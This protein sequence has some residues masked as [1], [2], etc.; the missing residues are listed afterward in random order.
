MQLS[1]CDWWPS[2]FSKTVLVFSP[3]EPLSYARQMPA[4]KQKKNTRTPADSLWGTND[5]KERERGKRKEKGK[6]TFTEEMFSSYDRFYPLQSRDRE[7]ISSSA[8]KRGTAGKLRTPPVQSIFVLRISRGRAT[9]H[10]RRSN[11][12]G[13][14]P[15]PTCGVKEKTAGTLLPT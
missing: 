12:Y 7:C 6:N 10:H 4:E 13:L 8:V 1:K 14:A 3:C 9:V 2:L 15:M 5:E 11:D